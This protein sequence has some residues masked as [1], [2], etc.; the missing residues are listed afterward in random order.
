MGYVEYN[1]MAEPHSGGCYT[2]VAAPGTLSTFGK[3]LAEPEGRIYFAGTETGT[4][5]YGYMEGAIEAGERASSQ[6]LMMMFHFETQ[7]WICL[8]GLLTRI[9]VTT[10]IICFY[11]LV[12]FC[13]SI[14]LCV[15]LSTSF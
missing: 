14:Q 13:F 10:S 6:V 2:G 4:Y 9:P 12:D 11:C 7:R 8:P 3:F 15:V 5:W 1:W